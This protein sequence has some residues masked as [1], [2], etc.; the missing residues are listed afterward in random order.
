MKELGVEE[1]YAILVKVLNKTG[2]VTLTED[3]LNTGEDLVLGAT[4]FEE[5]IEF[6]AEPSGEVT[7]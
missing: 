4:S 6:F 5:E 1:L 3:D 2:P 7:E